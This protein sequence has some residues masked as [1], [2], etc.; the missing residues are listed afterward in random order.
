MSYLKIDVKKGKGG[1]A[2]AKLPNVLILDI[3]DI[4]TMPMRDDKEVLH[5]GDIVMKPGKTGIYVYMTPSTIASG[6]TTEGEEDSHTIKQKFEGTFPGDELEINEFIAYWKDRNVIILTGTCQDTHMK[7][8]GTMCAPLQLKSEG[9]DN[10]D[11]NQHKMM[12]EAYAKSGYLPGFYTG[13]KPYNLT[14]QKLAVVSGAMPLNLDE[15]LIFTVET[16][17]GEKIVFDA[18]ANITN[19]TRISIIGKGGTDPAYIDATSNTTIAPA[20]VLLKNNITWY[21]TEDSSITFE[22]VNLSGVISLLEISRS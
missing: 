9:I 3:E 20:T 22:K 17:G 2:K 14:T 7:M 11:A 10:K 4:Q 18:I 19:G 8:Y 15:G 1:A 21:G 6:Y 12:F 16:D 13:T 5:A